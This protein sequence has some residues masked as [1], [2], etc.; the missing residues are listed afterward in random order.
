MLTWMLPGCMSAWKKPSRKTWVKKIVTP[1][2]ASF[3]MSTPA[4]RRRCDLADRHAV[5]ALHHD[6]ARG[7]Q[8]PHHLGHQHQVQALHVAPQLRGVGGLAH[9]VELVVQVDVELG[10]HLARLQPLAVGATAARPSAPACA[11]AS[12]RRRS[13]SSMPGRSTLTA[14]SRPSFSV[15]KCTCAIDALAT[16]SASKL[17]KSSSMRP[18]E[19]LLDQRGAPAPPGTAA[20]GPAAW[21]A[22]R[23]RPAAAGRAASTAPGRT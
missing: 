10:H 7:A 17:A 3:L 6:H 9:Q 14:T 15:A 1:S 21:P 5:H 13:T 20:R 8:V 4:S 11:A 19:G 18:A 2:R 12:G 23:P 16:G 22:R